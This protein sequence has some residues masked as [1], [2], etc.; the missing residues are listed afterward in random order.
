MLFWHVGAT[1][2]IARYTFRDDRMDLR[3]LALGALEQRGTRLSDDEP[4]G[5]ELVRTR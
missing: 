3:M 1:I 5:V 2:A 4:C